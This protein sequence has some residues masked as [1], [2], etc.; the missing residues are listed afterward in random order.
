MYEDNEFDNVEAD[1]RTLQVTY[2]GRVSVLRVRAGENMRYK[3][4]ERADD[5]F[6]STL[7]FSAFF[8]AL[9]DGAI[10]L[11]AMLFGFGVCMA[12]VG[13]VV[14]YTVLIL[15]PWAKMRFGLRRAWI[16]EIDGKPAV[17]RQSKRI[18][19]PAEWIN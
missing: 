13:I 2:R 17:K 11:S 12:V 3:M 16:A 7:V 8:F 6:W 14:L 4:Q 9:G 5:L 10:L 19:P 15:Y 18:G 1:S